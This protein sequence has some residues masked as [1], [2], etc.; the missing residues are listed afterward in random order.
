MTMK[1]LRFAIDMNKVDFIRQDRNK[2]IFSLDGKEISTSFSDSEEATRCFED[3]LEFMSIRLNIFD[4]KLYT[5]QQ[6]GEIR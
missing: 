3:A 2:I 6:T 5:D 1:K 4:L